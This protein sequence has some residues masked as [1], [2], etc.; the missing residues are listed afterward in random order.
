MNVIR[1]F[2]VLM[3]ASIVVGCSSSQIRSYDDSSQ[4]NPHVD[5]QIL[6]SYPDRTHIKVGAISVRH[7]RPGFRDPTV[8]DARDKLIEAGRQ[9]GAN[10]V[11]IIETESSNRTILIRGEGIKLPDVQ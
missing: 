3:L 6:Y 7:Y 5:I 2:S 10:A 1:L 9:L 11:V 4:A 8:E